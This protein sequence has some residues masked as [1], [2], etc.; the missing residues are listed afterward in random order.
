M[1]QITSSNWVDPVR[2]ATSFYISGNFIVVSH[3][4]T[5]VVYDDRAR[6]VMSITGTTEPI[7]APKRVSSPI[8]DWL[9]KHF[10]GKTVLVD[11]A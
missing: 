9:K 6:V 8:R 4:S 7:P 1:L 11:A 3:G 5:Q 10:S 2:E